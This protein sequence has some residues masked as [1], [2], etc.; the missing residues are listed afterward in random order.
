MGA[1]MEI[2]VKSGEVYK[3]FKGKRYEVVTL[4]KDSEDGGL[5]VVYKALYPPYETFVRPYL[6]FVEE[7]NPMVYPA[8]TQKHRFEKEVIEEYVKPEEPSATVPDLS[9]TIPIQIDPGLAKFLSGET[10]D[11]QMEALREMKDHISEEM[12]AI[13]FLSLDLPMTPGNEQE[14]Y[15]ALMKRLETMHEFDGKRFR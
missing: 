15:D 14:H 12:F 8:A 4:A 7:L 10:Y 1:D 6:S 3:H 13:M 9:A 5:M 11:A 2:E